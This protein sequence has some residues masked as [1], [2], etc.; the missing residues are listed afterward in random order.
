MASSDVAVASSRKHGRVLDNSL[1]YD[2]IR[3]QCAQ[4]P[5][6]VLWEDRQFSGNAV[7]ARPA[8]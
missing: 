5:A 3:Q 7:C 2:E 1:S 6:G 4:L 8:C